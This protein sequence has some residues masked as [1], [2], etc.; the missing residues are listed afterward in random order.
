MVLFAALVDNI[1]NYEEVARLDC[2]KWVNK[3]SRH[4]LQQLIIVSVDQAV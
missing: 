3:Q 1:I 4:K 2:E